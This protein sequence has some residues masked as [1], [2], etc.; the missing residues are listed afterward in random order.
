MLTPFSKDDPAL[1]GGLYLQRKPRPS[2]RDGGGSITPERSSVSGEETGYA[3]GHSLSHSQSQLQYAGVNDHRRDWSQRYNEMYDGT[4]PAFI[5]DAVMEEELR[6]PGPFPLEE[7]LSHP[8]LLGSLL[9]YLTFYDWCVLSSATKHIGGFLQDR[10]ELKE[11]VLERFMSMV[12][13]I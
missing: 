9:V 5:G 4:R 12:G 8:S 11:E 13:Y 7:F 3:Q 2:S 10:T 6:E 1:N